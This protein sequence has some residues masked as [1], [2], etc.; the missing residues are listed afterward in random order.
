MDNGIAKYPLPLKDIE[1]RRQRSSE[2]CILQGH[3]RQRGF[4]FAIEH[5]EFEKQEFDKQL[6][7]KIDSSQFEPKIGK[8]RAIIII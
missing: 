8:S 2:S 6:S 1:R 7:T 3:L 5:I 4:R